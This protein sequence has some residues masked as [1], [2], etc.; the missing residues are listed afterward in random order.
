M[1]LSPSLHR[2][3][4]DQVNV[5]LVE[6]HTG[7]TIVDA[8]LPGHYDEVVSELAVMGRSLDDVRGVVLTHGDTDHI[9]FAERLR[10]ERGIQVYVHQLTRLREG[11]PAPLHHSIAAKVFCTDAA[12]EVATLAVQ[13]HGGNGMTR[14]YPVEMFLRDATAFTIAD[15]ENHLL[16][17]IGAAML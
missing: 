7:I 3:G 6:D 1:R 16:S 9:G 8:G 11:G 10:V 2:V 14:A 12:L 13:L 15:G 5:Y 17:Q 4:S